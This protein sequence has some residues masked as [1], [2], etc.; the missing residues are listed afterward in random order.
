MPKSLRNFLIAPALWQRA[1]FCRKEAILVKKL[2]IN[3]RRQLFDQ[4]FFEP[5]CI[6]FRVFGKDMQYSCSLNWEAASNMNSTWMLHRVRETFLFHALTFPSPDKCFA[7]NAQQPMSSNRK[8]N[9]V[10]YLLI[11]I[12]ANFMNYFGIDNK[13]LRA[14]NNNLGQY[15][16]V[17]CAHGCE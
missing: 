6:H 8:S 9:V 13:P 10:Q 1:P 7:R 11:A 4:N 12:F 17:M 2:I 3:W 5:S 16:H 14:P 15:I